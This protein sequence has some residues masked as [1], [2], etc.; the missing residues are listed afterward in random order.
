MKKIKFIASDLDGT[1]LNSL[2]ALSFEDSAAITE[3][4]RLGILFVPTTGR[5]LYEIP[6]EVREHPAIKYIISSNGAVINDLRSGE[7]HE[8]M[9]DGERVKK[10]HALMRKYD[11]FLSHHKYGYGLVDADMMSE[12]SLD[13]HGIREYYR[14]L[15]REHAKAIPEYDSHFTSGDAAEMLVGFFSD[16]EKM[17][18]CEREINILGGVITTRSTAG[19]IEV[20]SEGA[21]KRHA[22]ERFA[23]LI[24]ADSREY[25]TVGDNYN[26]IGML[27]LTEN[28][29]A[30]SN[31]KDE[32]KAAAGRVIPSNDENIA[33]YIYES[34]IV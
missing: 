14:N 29:M 16:E 22:V 15:F 27:M 32:V 13:R 11:A 3:L 2:G 18:K 30:T 25:I 6:S 26:D 10:I 33:K 5:A 9:I 4:D 8:S 20:I 7:R 21:G 28:S 31:A 17:E 34:I 19:V 12:Q 23:R 24:S 1:L